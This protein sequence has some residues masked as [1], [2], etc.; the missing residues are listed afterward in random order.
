M[1]LKVQQQIE[2]SGYKGV[3]DSSQIAYS[4]KTEN[5]IEVMDKTVKDKL[6]EGE[7]F[8]QNTTLKEKVVEMLDSEHY[9]KSYAED[10]EDAAIR[11]EAAKQDIIS[12]Q[13][14][15]NQTA[16][17]TVNTIEEKKQQ[18]VTQFNEQIT[19]IQN[20]E[21][22]VNEFRDSFDADRQFQIMSE[23]EYNNLLSKDAGTVYFLW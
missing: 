2:S 20:I 10:A 13:N 23:E 19:K 18:V 8:D 17:T 21:N 11:A 22:A 1:A 3:A 7:M 15:I 16:V 14:A 6:D 12:R 4:Y 5:G 9:A